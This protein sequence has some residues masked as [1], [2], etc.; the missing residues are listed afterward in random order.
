M[1]LFTQYLESNNKPNIPKIKTE[2]R[3]ILKKKIKN[4][5]SL[6]S[7]QEDGAKIELIFDKS[8]FDYDEGITYQDLKWSIVSALR[9]KFSNKLRVEMV[10]DL[11]EFI[12]GNKL[13]ITIL[14]KLKGY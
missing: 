7:L 11:K 13:T 8:L 1:S 3:N 14:K 10:R 12:I 6:I 4:P 9:N 5:N 2:I